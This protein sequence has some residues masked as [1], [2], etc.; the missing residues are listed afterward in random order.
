LPLFLM[1]GALM[2]AR[3]RER[4]AAWLLLAGAMGGVVAVYK[5][6]LGTI[7]V[8]L[9]LV[10]LAEEGRWRR[11]GSTLAWLAAGLAVPVLMVAAWFAKR[12]AFGA[13]WET[14]VVIP[15]QIAGQTE[16]LARLDVLVVGVKWFLARAGG[17]VVLGAIGALLWWVERRDAERTPAQV[18]RDWIRRAALA[19]VAGG[20]LAVLLQVQSWW[21]YHWLLLVPALAMLGADAI[22]GLGSMRAAGGTPSRLALAA[23][24]AVGLAAAPLAVRLV[25]RAPLVAAGWRA[26]DPGGREAFEDFANPVAALQRAAA[27]WLAEKRV[28]PGPIYVWG[29]PLIYL[30][31]GR[32]Q[33]SPIQGWNLS[34]M[35]PSLYDRLYAD[36]EQRPPAA[37]F[38]ERGS[39]EAA[40]RQ[41]TAVAA[42]LARYTRA[43]ELASGTWY[44]RTP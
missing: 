3:R 12:D 34:L 33:A 14:L 40:L 37:V 20:V 27:R 6:F 7:P 35:A 4:P 41:D 18:E 16:V 9:V 5:P 10:Y 29:S 32:S 2:A 26:L 31:S 44:T 39:K 13:L 8:A 17:L 36:L 30:Y 43:A 28:A 25:R 22:R 38:V 21:D 23:W 15:G 1:F 42:L 19:W 24:L 11:S